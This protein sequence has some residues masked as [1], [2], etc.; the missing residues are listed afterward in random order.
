MIEEIKTDG[1]YKVLITLQEGNADF[2]YLMSDYHLQIVPDGT[3]DFGNGIGTGGY[4]LVSFEPGVNSLVKRNPNYWKEGR[5]HFDEVETIGIN[6]VNART[7]ALRTGQVDVIARCDMKTFHLLAKSP[8]IQGVKTT[9]TRH[10]TIP[11]HSDFKPYDNNDVR[12]ALKYVIDREQLLKTV[13][14]GHGAIGNDH[15]ISPANRYFASELPQRMYDPDKARY[16][17]K[18]AGLKDHVFNL[19][20]ADAAFQGAV[21]VALLYKEQAAKAGININVIRT[22]NDGYWNDIWL[23]KEWCLSYWWGRPTEDWMLSSTYA[24]GSNWNEGFWKHDRFNDLL[25][26]ARTELDE[27][28]RRGMYVEMQRIIC[29][30]GASVIP[31]FPSDLLA[32]TTKLKYGKVASNIEMD[33]YRLHERWWFE[34]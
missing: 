32:A 1:R 14:R 25:K 29:D 13:L 5:A 10:Y 9:G 28:K 2:P 4:S 27:K 15:P 19:Y 26:A 16:Y 31:L 6:D 34:S 12:L 22:P 24:A 20:A 18:K 33:G 11:M 8:G 17:F 23:K 3:T 30:E 7:S 21:D